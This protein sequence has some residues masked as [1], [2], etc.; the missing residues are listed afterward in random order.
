MINQGCFFSLG[1]NSNADHALVAM[2][3]QGPIWHFG[4]SAQDP[5]F[6][7][8]TVILGDETSLFWL[9]RRFNG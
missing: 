6:R 9:A 5:A 8:K 2:Q 4:T 3:G 1:H 7:K